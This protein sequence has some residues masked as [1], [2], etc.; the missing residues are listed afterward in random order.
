MSRIQTLIEH[1]RKYVG[2]PARGH[3]GW[4]IVESARAAGFTVDSAIAAG[5]LPSGDRLLDVVSRSAS[6]ISLDE[7]RAGDVL[8]KGTRRSRTPCHLLLMT[9][10][11]SFVEVVTRKGTVLEIPLSPELRRLIVGAYRLGGNVG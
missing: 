4:V 7:A 3:C 10:D 6:P 9:S 5:K 11:D 8:V 1:A 2:K